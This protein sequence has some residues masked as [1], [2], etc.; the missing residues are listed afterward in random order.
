MTVHPF[1]FRADVK[2]KNGGEIHVRCFGRYDSSLWGDTFAELK[3][4]AKPVCCLSLVF[5]DP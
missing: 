2:L 1:T 4:H 3:D 5:R